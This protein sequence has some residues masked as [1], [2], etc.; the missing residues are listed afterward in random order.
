MGVSRIIFSRFIFI[1]FSG[2]EEPDDPICIEDVDYVTTPKSPK[3]TWE[4]R[5]EK[6]LGQLIRRIEQVVHFSVLGGV[7][8]AGPPEV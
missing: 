7:R 1:Y 3:D 2:T 8:L 5:T 6:E 4:G